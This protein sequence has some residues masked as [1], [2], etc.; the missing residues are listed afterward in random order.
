MLLRGQYDRKRQLPEPSLEG[1]NPTFVHL[2]SSVDQ[3][4]YDTLHK[5]RIIAFE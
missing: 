4:D 1:N 3:Q 5:C 2:E